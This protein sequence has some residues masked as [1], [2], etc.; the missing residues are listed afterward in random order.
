MKVFV[1]LRPSGEWV[2]EVV[3]G[4]PRRP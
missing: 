3:G 1:E 2:I 4:V